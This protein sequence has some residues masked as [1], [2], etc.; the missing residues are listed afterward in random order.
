MEQDEEVIYII[1]K[2]NNHINN[3]YL[4]SQKERTKLFLQPNDEQSKRFFEEEE[5][6]K[7]RIESNK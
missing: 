1:S 6:R 4:A 5:K 2:Y 7:I 3:Q